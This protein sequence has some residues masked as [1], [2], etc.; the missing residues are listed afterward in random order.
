MD[1]VASSAP[2]VASEVKLDLI[3]TRRTKTFNLATYKYHSLGDYVEHIKQYG[4]TDSYS[5]ERVRPI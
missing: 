4:T 1:S 3:A 2:A 5:T